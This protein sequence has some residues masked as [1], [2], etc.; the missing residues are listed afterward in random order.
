MA[1]VFQDVFWC[2]AGVDGAF[3]SDGLFWDEVHA[4]MPCF[5]SVMMSRWLPV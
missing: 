4:L 2:L 5:V 3:V 1:S